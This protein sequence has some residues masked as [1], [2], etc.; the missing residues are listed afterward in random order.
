MPAEKEAALRAGV[1]DYLIKPGDL[2]NV[3]GHIAKWVGAKRDGG[4]ISWNAD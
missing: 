4:R 1:Q 3:A 2:F